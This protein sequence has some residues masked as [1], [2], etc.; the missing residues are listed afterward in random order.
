[1]NTVYAIVEKFIIIPIIYV[2]T[3]MTQALIYVVRRY[4]RWR[5][6]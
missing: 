5:R 1:M 6:K 2:L 3:K 4:N